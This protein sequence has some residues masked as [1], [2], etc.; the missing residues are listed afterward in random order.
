MWGSVNINSIHMSTVERG[1]EVTTI[2]CCTEEHFSRRK[3]SR[4]GDDKLTFLATKMH[5]WKSQNGFYYISKPVLPSALGINHG[6]KRGYRSKIKINQ[7]HRIYATGTCS[8]SCW[9]VTGLSIHLGLAGSP[10]TGCSLIVLPLWSRP[11]WAGALCFQNV[12][13]ITV[14]LDEIM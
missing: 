12:Q 6:T 11:L 4:W 8:L 10:W 5:K 1:A 3:K 13:M 7:K 2:P 9:W 14:L